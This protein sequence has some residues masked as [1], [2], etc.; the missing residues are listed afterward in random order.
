MAT[1]GV[2]WVK[3]GY[4]LYIDVKT[5]GMVALLLLW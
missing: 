4:F 3:I 1:E 2:F 5:C